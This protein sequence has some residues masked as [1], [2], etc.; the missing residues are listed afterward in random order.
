[1]IDIGGSDLML[2]IDHE[3]YDRY[4]ALLR[5]R[6]GIDLESYRM[7]DNTSIRLARRADD[8]QMTIDQYL[9][10]LETHDEE[11]GIARMFLS[12]PVSWFFREEAVC[13]RLYKCILPTLIKTSKEVRVW[14]PGCAQGQ[15]LYTIAMILS[16]L[17]PE[18]S[19]SLYGTDINDQCVAAARTGAYS[20]LDMSYIHNRSYRQ[21]FR[22]L[23]RNQWL[24][25][26]HIR[27]N[28]VFSCHDLVR[29]VYP[30]DFDLVI[31]RNVEMYLSQSLWD[32]VARRLIGSLSLG[33]VL[34]TDHRS[35]R[36]DC[37]EL[38]LRRLNKDF[39]RRVR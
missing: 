39:Y 2:H 24:I 5:A 4:A 34:C 7:H 3:Q 14:N 19:Y 26:D 32:D 28:T 38:G 17:N 29:E 8:L 18:A 16:T 36:R 15:Q 25:K 1:M 33:G 10:D 9:D 37:A 6:T 11:W 20:D 30:T 12:T 31:Y 23:G 21:F 27:A 13:S 22:R 35:S